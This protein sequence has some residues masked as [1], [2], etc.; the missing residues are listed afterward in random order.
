MKNGWAAILPTS[1]T[2]SLSR[3]PGKRPS[4]FRVYSVE[5]GGL[6]FRVFWGLGFRGLG[7]IRLRLWAF[8]VQAVDL[9][10]SEVMV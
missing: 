5:A 10:G 9:F 2:T 7:F 8:R 3:D 4:V 6:G 1:C